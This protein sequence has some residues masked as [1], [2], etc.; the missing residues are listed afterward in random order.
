MTSDYEARFPALF[1][2]WAENKCGE[3][4]ALLEDSSSGLTDVQRRKLEADISFL[5]H[6]IAYHAEGPKP[7]A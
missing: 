2:Q 6:A 1:V 7:D 4:S 5:T 3:W